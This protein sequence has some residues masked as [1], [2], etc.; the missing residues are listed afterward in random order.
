MSLFAIAIVMAGAVMALSIPLVAAPERAIAFL[1]RF[2]RSRIAGGVLSAVSLCWAATI[3][4]NAELG[5]FNSLK[6][7]IMLL[8]VVLFFLVFFLMDELLASRALGGFF[9]LA[10]TP[11]LNA[12][13]WH[14]S[15]MRLVPVVLAYVIV[16]AGMILVLNPYMFR[17]T[18]E[19]IGS[20]APRWRAIGAGGIALS[21]I[22]LALSFLAY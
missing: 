11:I 12:A 13:R 4:Y 3:V 7:A 5:N 17:K 20:S 6:P 10:A 9:L 18:V 16:V 14:P 1:S 22:L 19:R 2:P 8:A 15:V 21:L